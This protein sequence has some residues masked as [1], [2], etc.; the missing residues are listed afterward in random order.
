MPLE[1][2]D[3]T[4]TVMKSMAKFKWLLALLLAGYVGLVALMYAAQ[5]KLMYFPDTARTRPADAG[6]PEAQEVFLD[7]ADGEKIVAWHIPPH[8]GKPLVV[9]FHGNGAALRV[10]VRRFRTLTADGTGLLALSYRGYG[11]STGSPSEQGLIRDAEAAYAFAAAR[12]SAARI[13]LWGKS[14][15]SAVAIALASEKP[16]ARL[17]LEAPFTSAADVGAAAYPFIPVRLLMKDSFHSDA[18]VGKV[19]APVLILHGDDDRIVP[20]AFGERLYELI[21]G[22]KRF[23]R[24]AGGGHRNLDSHGAQEEVHKFLSE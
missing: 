24:L 21:K 11:G 2:C 13:V 5:R 6:L 8:E 10:R 14:L 16:V 7:T 17:I 4:F 18:R 22:P 12:Y 1:T 19:T 15:G 3:R 20:I 9:Y 23:V